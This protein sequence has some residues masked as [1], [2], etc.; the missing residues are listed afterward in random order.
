[1]I[2]DKISHLHTIWADLCK[3]LNKPGGMTTTEAMNAR[4]SDI[5]YTLVL[6]MH[7]W[8]QSGLIQDYVPGGALDP[9]KFET[10]LKGLC[11]VNDLR[12]VWQRAEGGDG[13]AQLALEVYV[14]RLRR[15]L[16]QSG[17]VIRTVRGLGYRCCMWF[18]RETNSS[19]SALVSKE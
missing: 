15:K 11:G 9:A 7:K 18:R 13:A 16:E 8:Y 5:G 12:E 1:M 2:K 3:A 10:A 4:S 6:A 17:L 14:H 19:Y